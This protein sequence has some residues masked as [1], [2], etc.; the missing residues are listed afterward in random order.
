MLT[1]Y[2]MLFLV[3]YVCVCVCMFLRKM[4]QDVFLALYLN[5]ANDIRV[6]FSPH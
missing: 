1:A 3:S 5:R 2:F 6:A 4:N